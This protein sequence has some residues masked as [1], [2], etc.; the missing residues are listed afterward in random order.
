MSVTNDELRKR[1]ECYAEPAQ[2]EVCDHLGGGYDGSVFSTNRQS[3][4]KCFRHHELYQNELRVYRR[5]RSLRIRQI[6]GFA[7]PHLVGDDESL[8]LIEISIVDPPFVLDFAGAYLDRRPDFPRSVMR[9]WM[10]EKQDQFGDR[11]PEVQSLMSAFARH[12]IYLADVKPGN[13][14]FADEQP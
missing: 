8:A 7:V 6:K 14:M 2:I 1:A 13:I 9:R 3:A 11:W 5:L 4:I 10:A 12:G